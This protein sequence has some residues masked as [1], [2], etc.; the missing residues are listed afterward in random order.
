MI[1]VKTKPAVNGI[2]KIPG[3]KSVSHRALITSALAKGESRLDGFLSCEDTLFTA[4]ALRQLGVD[5]TLEGNRITIAGKGGHFG[6]PRA[7]KEI[8]LGSSGTSIRL[9]LSIAALSPG[10]TVLTGAPRM[11]E[12]PIGDLVDALKVL[13]ARI[14]YHNCQG[15]PP[16]LTHGGGLRGGK[17][18]IPG[19]KSSQYISSLLLAGPYAREEVEIEVTGNLVSRPYLDITLRVMKDFGIP[20]VREGYR[21]FKI[22]SGITYQPRSYVIEG[23]VSTASYFWAAAA[24]AGG[25][26]TTENIY[27][28]TVQGDIEFLNVLEKMGCKV[29]RFHDCVSVMGCRLSGIEVDMGAMPDMVPT[30]AAISLFAEGETAIRNVAHLRIKESDRLHAIAQEWKKIGAH[31]DELEDGL[32]IR[33]NRPLMGAP[34]NSHNDHRIAMSLAVVGLN[35]KGIEIEEEECVTKSFP[36]FWSFW[37][38]L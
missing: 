18:V 13:G 35:V 25:A 3:S 24:V 33:G 22:P 36:A 21:W 2:V 1:T 16:I 27:P 19:D 31:L 11:H 37:D 12:R 8:Y 14:S 7:L 4:N 10:P 32:V 6:D 5:L 34:V 15:Y 38:T 23:D 28:D 20:V 30:L 17:V 26:V 29:E 9:L